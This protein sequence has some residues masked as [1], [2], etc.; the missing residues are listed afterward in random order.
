MAT[1]MN[2]DA[3]SDEFVRALAR[4]MHLI[5]SFEGSRFLTLTEAAQRTKL[6]RGTTRRLLLTLVHLGYIGTDGHHFWLRP[7]LMALGHAYLS[8]LSLPDLLLPHMEQ[9]IG[10][11]VQVS[12]SAAVLDDVDIVFVAGVPAKTLIRVSMTAGLRLPATASAMGRVLLA[13]LPDQELLRRLQRAVPIQGG[14][15]PEVLDIIQQTRKRAHGVADREID[16]SMRSVAVAVRDREGR[17]VAAMSLT[18]H[19]VSQTMKQVVKNCLPRLQLAAQRLSKEVPVT[20]QG[21]GTS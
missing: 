15:V 6:S 1:H 19:D 17:C 13:E 14:S 8:G 4:G 12:S 10:S 9:M 7:R 5:E 2:E 11:D 18:S 3:D 20:I 21:T 16:T